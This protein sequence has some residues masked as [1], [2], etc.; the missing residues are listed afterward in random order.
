MSQ[1]DG[2]AKPQRPDMNQG[3]LCIRFGILILCLLLFLRSL[4]PLSNLTR[5]FG[6][7]SLWL[8]EPATDHA[9]P[10]ATFIHDTGL[11]MP[12]GA[13][14]L[15][16]GDTHGG[17]QND[18]DTYLAFRTD[19]DR[20]RNWLALPPPFGA[21]RWESGELPEELR[22]H[23][24]HGP[25]SVAPRASR[26]PALHYVRR[27]N[28]PASGVLLVLNLNTGRAWYCSWTF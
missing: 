21:Q 12:D 28:S 20:L 22:D 13:V 5:F 25:A 7:L 3:E 23:C 4:V 27:G 15:A 17:M 10:V 11:A 16:S 6:L 1:V 8:S 24:R 26:S 18:G 14:V 2:S 19:P 9:D